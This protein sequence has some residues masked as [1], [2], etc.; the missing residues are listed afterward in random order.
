MNNAQMRE[1]CRDI[2][3][4]L[5]INNGHWTMV[6]GFADGHV[7]LLV[8]ENYGVGLSREQLDKLSNYFGKYFAG[9]QF[10]G[11]GGWSFVIVLNRPE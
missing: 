7:N 1:V 3:G 2:C 5:N 9:I 4:I 8:S 10:A 6:T 11:H